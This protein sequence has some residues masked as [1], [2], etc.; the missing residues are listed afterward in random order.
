MIKM[1]HPQFLQLNSL[2]SMRIVA[3]YDFSIHNIQLCVLYRLYNKHE[4]EVVFFSKTSR[5]EGSCLVTMYR[6]VCQQVYNI[7]ISIIYKRKTLKGSRLCQRFDLK[8]FSRWYTNRTQISFHLINLL[9]ELIHCH[10]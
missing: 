2:N 7:F 4:Y 8:R 9:R 5:W 10:C 3:H 6:A 1:V